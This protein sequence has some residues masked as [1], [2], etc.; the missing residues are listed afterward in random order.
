MN[1]EQIMELGVDEDVAGKIIESFERET[2]VLRKEN[3]KLKTTFESY[4]AQLNELDKYKTDHDA[5]TKKFTEY[6]ERHRDEISKFKQ[7][8]SEFKRDMAIGYAM[9]TLE[10]TPY[11]SDLVLSLIDKGSVSVDDDG[12]ISGFEEQIQDLMEKK[13]FLFKRQSVNGAD[14]FDNDADTDDD[15]ESDVNEDENSSFDITGTT[16]DVSDH[17]VEYD[18]FESSPS[19]GLRLARTTIDRGGK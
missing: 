16:P 5:L 8:M 13:S 15:L 19:I 11:D 12:N 9:K 2:G 14:S 10:A 3:E 1:I 17:S 18:S 7:E 6:K 4:T